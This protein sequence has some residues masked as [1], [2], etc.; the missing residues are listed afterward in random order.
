MKFTVKIASLS[1]LVSQLFISCAE[2]SIKYKPDA[3]IVSFSNEKTE[4]EISKSFVIERKMTFVAFDLVNT[5]EFN[6]EEALNEEFPNAKKFINLRIK[7]EEAT[8]D[9]V[10]RF[11]GTLM[12]YMFVTNRA[13]VSRRT[14][15]ISGEVI[16]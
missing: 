3:K 10:I 1:L 8:T 11:L 7:S 13:I 12:Q 2:Y 15:T 16:E 6:L 4:G 5:Q 14:V 9:S